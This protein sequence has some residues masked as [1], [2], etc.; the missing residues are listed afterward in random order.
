MSFQDT[1]TGFLLA[2]VGNVDLRR[3]TNYLIVDSS[4][5]TTS[6]NNVVIYIWFVSCVFDH[7]RSCF[8]IN[9]SLCLTKCINLCDRSIN[10]QFYFL[11]VTSI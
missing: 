11:S 4:M 7:M 8:E 10:S 3:K 2:G 9:G 5:C 6:L 1:V